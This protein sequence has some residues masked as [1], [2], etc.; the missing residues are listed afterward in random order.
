MPVLV[1]G[2]NGQLGSELCRQVSSFDPEMLVLVD[3][4]E[5]GLYAIHEDLRSLRRW[6]LE[7]C[8]V[9]PPHHGANL[10]LGVPQGEVPMAALVGLETGHL[11]PDPQR[12][13]AALE[14]PPRRLGEQ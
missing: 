11:T 6:L 4:D 13:E 3:H 5:S 2:A 1:T 7:A 8:G 10:R 14:D 12:P 9:G